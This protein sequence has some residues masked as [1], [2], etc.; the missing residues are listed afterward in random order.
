MNRKVFE[1]GFKTTEN[2]FPKVLEIEEE[3]SKIWKLLEKT[4]LRRVGW[5]IDKED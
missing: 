2:S 3:M 5:M 4:K 1:M